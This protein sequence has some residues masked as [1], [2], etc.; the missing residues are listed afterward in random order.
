MR[1]A[2]GEAVVTKGHA[3]HQWDPLGPT[4]HVETHEIQTKFKL[5]KEGG[6]SS[7]GI[8][9]GEP[10]IS[11]VPEG[12]CRPAHN[13]PCGGLWSRSWQHPTWQCAHAQFL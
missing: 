3:D 12:V 6:H 13:L 7:G 2:T 9:F 10:H 5:S 4:H 11:A 1:T 8:K